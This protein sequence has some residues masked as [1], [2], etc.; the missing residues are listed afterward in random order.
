MIRCVK[1]GRATKRFLILAA[2]VLGVVFIPSPAE[3]LD[4]KQSFIDAMGQGAV[5]VED[6]NRR[7]ILSHRA[8]DSLLPASTIKV[9]TAA[10]G[11]DVL[12]GDFRFL[13]EFYETRD[14]KLVVKGYGDPFLVSQEIARIARALKSRGLNQVDGIILDASYFAPNIRVDGSSASNNP[15]DALNSALLVNFNTINVKKL[16]NGTVVSAEAQTPITPLA[17]SLAKKMRAGVG[18]INLGD[19]PQ[20]ALRYAGE[21]IAAFLE[22]EGVKVSGPIT[23]GL[24]PSDAELVYRHESGKNLAEIIR[25]MLEFSTNLT[26]N[27]VFLVMGATRLGAPATVEKGAQVMSQFLRQKVGWND[28]AV[29][30]GSGLSR[31]TH[32]T[33]TQ[34]MKLLR[35]FEND[36]EL[37]PLHDETFRAKTGTLNGVNTYMG[38]FPLSGGHH[39]RFVILVNDNVPFGHKF[40]MAKMLYQYMHGAKAT[41]LAQ[42]GSIGQ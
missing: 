19:N 37:L 7:V 25:D 38:Y 31:R 30:E 8:D 16:K 40:K 13:T 23:A 6:E 1:P 35:Y 26:A 2:W 15:Y 9:A 21:L 34:M 28:F 24:V 4:W 27:Q 39:A 36:R 3:A 22:E 5:L 12:G 11:L 41:D 29:T 18:R 20:N 33:A 14:G 10:C 42:D 17:K 32:V